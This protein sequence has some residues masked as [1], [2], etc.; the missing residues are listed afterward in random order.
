[1]AALIDLSS[2]A[3]D[4]VLQA[5]AP[6]DE[7]RG[8][9]FV[10]E[11]LL[12]PLAAAF[13]AVSLNTSL[14]LSGDFDGRRWEAT[15]G[16]LLGRFVAPLF[17]IPATG[18]LAWLR[19]G[20][21]QRIIEGRVAETLLLLDVPS[22][23]LQAGEWPLAR[24]LGPDMM[25]PPPANL[26]GDG[27]ASLAVVEAMIAGLMR[28]D[29]RDLASMRMRDFWSDDFHW[30]GPAPIGAFQGHDDYERGHQRPFLTAFP[31]RRGGNH[32]ARIAEGAL[33]ASTGW[34][35]I[36][37]THSGG[38]WLGLAATRR[39]VTM[40]VMDFWVCRDGRLTD[41]WV[42]IDLIDLLRQ[43]GIDVFARMKAVSEGTGTWRNG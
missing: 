23:M 7:G 30:Y 37:A 28:Y 29:G 11:A 33:V 42:M 39:R 32:R 24:P 15:S 8:A 17:G 35:S 38:D 16:H 22:L 31:D 1:M 14:T 12:Q 10:A 13:P 9:A 3:D 40:R 43:L 34:P 26:E 18:R 5:G 6:V 2:L 21:F 25:A 36:A 4:H 20:R 41:N 19:F 27:A